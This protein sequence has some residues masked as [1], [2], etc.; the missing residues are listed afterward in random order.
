V[1][2]ANPILAKIIIAQPQCLQVC[3]IRCYQNRKV[4]VKSMD[5]NSSAHLDKS[6]FEG[7]LT[8]HLPNEIK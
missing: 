7:C 3:Y 4:S 6:Y 2:L 5:N 1:A 8:V